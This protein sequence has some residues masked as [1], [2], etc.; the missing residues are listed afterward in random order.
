V[1][2]KRQP[3]MRWVHDFG[4]ESEGFSVADSSETYYM[5]EA[6]RILKAAA[7]EALKTKIKNARA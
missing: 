2:R 6:V 4:S 3:R 1:P 5:A 7:A